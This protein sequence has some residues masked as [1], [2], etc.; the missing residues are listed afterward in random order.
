MTTLASGTVAVLR[1]ELRQA[2][3]TP[4]A[5]ALIAV[6]WAASGYFFSF[7]LFLANVTEMVTTFHNMSI[8]LLLLVPLLTMRS[9]ADES[10]AGTLELLM[11]LPLGSSAIVLGKLVAAELVLLVMIAGSVTA[12]VPLL[13]FA[14]PDLGPVLGGYLGVLLLGTA[15]VGIGLFVSSLCGSQIVAAAVTWAVLLLLWFL[16]YGAA[17]SGGYGLSLLLR[18]LSFSEHYLDLIRGVVTSGTVAYLLG[19][20][21][22]MVA[23]TI[24]GL[25][26]RRT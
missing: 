3:G 24:Q 21:L 4:I 17:L 20:T 12:L 15:F 2:F 13:L 9:F 1:K 5:Y 6:F 16:D 8:L 26:W 19:L 22:L 10:A 18:H 14:S 11:T 25:Q 7:S 23:F